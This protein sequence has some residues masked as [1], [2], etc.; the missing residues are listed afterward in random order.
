MVHKSWLFFHFVV[1]RCL[2]EIVT[3]QSPRHRVQ[4]LKTI[5]TKLPGTF[6]VVTAEVDWG[7][8]VV[9]CWFTTADA[10]FFTHFSDHSHNT[11]EQ[12]LQKAISHQCAH[13]NLQL[14]YKPVAHGYYGNSSFAPV[15][16]HEPSH[17]CSVD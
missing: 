15:S 16:T 13:W 4:I 7:V 14:R 10:E 6:D 5:L 3:P 11:D 17:N 9:G 2:C 8:G 12:I 1:L